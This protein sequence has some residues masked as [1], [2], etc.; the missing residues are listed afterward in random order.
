MPVLAR[1]PEYQMAYNREG[2]ETVLLT[3]TLGPIK[4]SRMAQGVEISYRQ[5]F[6]WILGV[7]TPACRLDH[8]HGAH[9]TGGSYDQAYLACPRSLNS[10]AKEGTKVIFTLEPSSGGTGRYP[11]YFAANVVCAAFFYDNACACCSSCN[12]SDEAVADIVSAAGVRPP[13]VKVCNHCSG[14]EEVCICCRWTRIG[15]SASAADGCLRAERTASGAKPSLCYRR[16]GHHSELYLPTTSCSRCT[17]GPRLK[18]KETAVDPVE[19]AE[20]CTATPPKKKQKA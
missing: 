5:P 16:S 17:K 15:E 13:Y 6:R 10:F 14:P 18:H 19:L 11:Q 7:T 2:L 1:A 9:C 8:V 3:G 4:Y 20:S 12:L